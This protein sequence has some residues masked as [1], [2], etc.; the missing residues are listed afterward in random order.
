MTESIF[1]DLIIIL[2]I[3]TSIGVGWRQ[4]AIASILAFIGV[5]SGLIIGGAAAPLLMGLTEK[6]FARFMLAIGVLIIS[7]GLG[8][9]VGISLGLKLRD[10]MRLKSLQTVDSAIGSVAQAVAV[11]VLIWLVSIPIVTGTSG[12]FSQLLRSSAVLST[13]NS[14]APDRAAQLPAQISAMLNESGLPPLVSPF[15]DHHK[16]QQVEAPRINVDNEQMVHDARPSIIH[17]MGESDQCRRRLM[18]TGFVTQDDYILTNAHVVAGTHSVRAD[19]VVGVR[20]AEVVYY[21]PDID[22]AVLHVPNLGLPALPWA[23]QPAVSGDDA[24]VMG[25]PQSGP[26]DASP[27]RVRDQIRISGPDIY[28]QG[29]VE[30]EVYTLRGNIRQGNSGGPVT[31][32]D[33]RV[34]GMVFGAA[35]DNSDTGYAL[36]AEEVRHQVG[37]L[38]ALV[39]PVETGACVAQ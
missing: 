3:L 36:T 1:V 24:V 32:D 2:V 9:L 19:T 20:E 38:G 17:V 27:A 35:V 4:G 25:F 21:N 16:S 22:I 33:G 10:A 18:G 26:F 6:T 34:I 7:A 13:M 15:E 23:E 14:L 5:V 11:S 30:R 12:S 28:A 39:G 37:E 8:H 29:R 31:T